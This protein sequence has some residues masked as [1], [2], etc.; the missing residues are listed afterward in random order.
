MIKVCP[1]IS[2]ITDCITSNLQLWRIV[3]LIITFSEI[4]VVTFYLFTSV[5]ESI[6]KEDVIAA[7]CYVGK[8]EGRFT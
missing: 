5:T 4:E 1:S 8:Y 6:K 2:Y 3:H 7:T